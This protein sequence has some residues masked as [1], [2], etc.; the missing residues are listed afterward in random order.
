MAQLQCEKCG[1]RAAAAKWAWIWYGKSF[2]GD[3][4]PKG[5]PETQLWLCPECAGEF[6]SDRARNAFLRKVL[7]EQDPGRR[8]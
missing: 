8:R 1:M 5:R 7:D 2:G 6:K 3:E 4:P